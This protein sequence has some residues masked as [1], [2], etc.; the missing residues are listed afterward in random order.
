MPG[1]HGG[2]KMALDPLPRVIVICERSHG[3]WDRNS[4]FLQKPQV[5]FT[6]DPFLQPLE[7]AF[8]D[9]KIYEPGATHL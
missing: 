5:T 7:L 9:L 6:A 8:C 2:Q 3:C 4:G 1:A